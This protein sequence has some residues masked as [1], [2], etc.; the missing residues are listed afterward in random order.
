MSTYSQ[1]VPDGLKPH[2]GERSRGENRDLPKR[3]IITQISEK[4]VRTTSMYIMTQ[5]SEE[6]VRASIRLPN[7][8]RQLVAFF[9]N[10]NAEM[11]LLAVRDQSDNLVILD[12]GK[13]SILIG[14]KLIK[15]TYTLY[16]TTN[17]VVNPTTEETAKLV[18][19]EREW[20][21]TRKCREISSRAYNLFRRL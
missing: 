12:G 8:N 10:E 1:Q 9:T 4:E 20:R 14:Q 5:V 11:Y 3:Y 19:Q 18:T 21:V 17:A 13:K 16:S 2:H 15:G 6:E 7:G